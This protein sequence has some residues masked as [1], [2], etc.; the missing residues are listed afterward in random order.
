VQTGIR[1]KINW[2]VGLAPNRLLVFH[3]PPMRAETDTEKIKHQR[4]PERMKAGR[5]TLVHFGKCW[6]WVRMST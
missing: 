6:P 4:W 5:C 2:F 3:A 1:F